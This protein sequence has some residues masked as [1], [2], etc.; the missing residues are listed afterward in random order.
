MNKAKLV[1]LA[2]EVL[3]DIDDASKDSLRQKLELN[4]CDALYKRFLHSYYYLR[5]TSE[6]GINR[7]NYE[8]AYKAVKPIL[9]DCIDKILGETNETTI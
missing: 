9:D 3:T 5:D 6:V 1:E 7:D 8:Y 4:I 2:N